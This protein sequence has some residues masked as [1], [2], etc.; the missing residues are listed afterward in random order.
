[1]V[2]TCYKMTVLDSVTW[3][4][5]GL[6]CSLRIIRVEYVEFSDVKNRYSDHV[7]SLGSVHVMVYILYHPTQAGTTFNSVGGD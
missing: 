2:G 4:E 7:L 1:M 3:L 5:S 6:N